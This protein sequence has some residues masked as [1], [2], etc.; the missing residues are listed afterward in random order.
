MKDWETEF[1]KKLITAEEAAQMVKP[2]DRVSFTLGREAF[3]IGLAIASR[4]GELRDVKIF[5]P[6]PGYDFGWYEPGW[7]EF[8]QITILMPTSVSQQMI[9]ERRGDIEINDIL[10]WS[11]GTLKESDVVITEV[12]PPD[13]KGFCSFGAALWNKKKHI[14]NA[15]LVLAEI[16]DRL[17][18]TYG[19][20][21]VHVSEIDYFV[22]HQ[23]S[24]AVTSSGSLG[25]REKREPAQYMKDI[26]RH[27]SELIRDGDTVQIGIGR[28]TERLVE[29]GLFDGKSDIGWY[30]EATPP[31]VIRLVREGVIN[32]KR[33]TLFPGKVIVTT[34]GGASKEDMDWASNNPLFWLVEVDFLWDVRNISANDNMVTI[35]QA[36]SIDLSGQVSAES[37]GHKIFSSAGGQTAFAYGALLSRGGRGIT[38]LPSTAKKRDGK[39][40]SRIVPAFEAGTAVT[41][42]RNCVDNVVTEYGIA[43]L[44]GKSLRQRC[45]EL[46]AVAHPD[47]RDEL[48]EAAKKLYWP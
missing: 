28:V 16:N 20:N 6:F 19:D 5:Q 7:E 33:K 2:G 39:L 41:V 21:F 8:F 27:V 1:E 34:L 31:G 42:T 25:G 38:I 12:S 18:R 30:S 35:N 26:T 10:C 47:F 3:S 48:R 32:G 14:K 46:I 43:R 15:K 44:R 29:L 22:P 36:L 40:T 37:I 45:E 24:G 9:D 13:E 17:I 23:E 4:I 11:E